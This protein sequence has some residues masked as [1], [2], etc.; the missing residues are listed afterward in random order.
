LTAE[1][2]PKV[3]L[4][5]LFHVVDA[6]GSEYELQVRRKSQGEILSNQL[7]EG[8][9]LRLLEFG[10]VLDLKEEIFRDFVSILHRVGFKARS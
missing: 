3:Q 4:L 2:N 7:V 10:M 1:I 6:C 5:L 8:Y 9:E